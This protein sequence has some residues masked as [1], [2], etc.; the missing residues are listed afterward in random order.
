M[1]DRSQNSPNKVHWKKQFIDD[2]KRRYREK[3]HSPQFYNRK[4]SF[5]SNSSS[6]S[7]KRRKISKRHSISISRTDSNSP[8][9]SNRTPSIK[10]GPSLSNMVFVDKKYLTHFVGNNEVFLR[11]VNLP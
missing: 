6:K 9:R 8:N 7:V 1:S 4:H 5:S 3:D 2:P 11:N 10:K